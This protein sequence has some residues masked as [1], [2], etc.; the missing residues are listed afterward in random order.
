ML[1]LL[2]GCG[3]RQSEVVGLRLDQ[4]RLK[5]GHW[6]IFNLIGKGGTHY[7]RAGLVQGAR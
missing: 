6:V 5:E 3:L 1:G 7:L 4:L 2:S